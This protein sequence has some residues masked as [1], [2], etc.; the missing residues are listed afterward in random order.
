MVGKKLSR[1]LW[2]G[3]YYY[4]KQSGNWRNANTG[5]ITK[6]TPSKI[7]KRKIGFELRKANFY[8]NDPRPR[9]QAL[10]R[11]EDTSPGDARRGKTAKTYAKKLFGGRQE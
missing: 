2:R 11:W 7:G 4:R 3:S 1:A 10:K 8:D 9:T 6:G 5:A